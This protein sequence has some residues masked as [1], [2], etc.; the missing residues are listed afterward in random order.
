[1]EIIIT[2]PSI[3]SDLWLDLCIKKCKK[4]SSYKIKK[5]LIPDRNSYVNS[6]SFYQETE[7]VI[8]GIKR[9]I[10]IHNEKYLKINQPT[11]EHNWMLEKNI[12]KEDLPCLLLHSD[13]IL[14]EDITPLV[15]SKKENYAVNCN[16][17]LL[18]KFQHNMNLAFTANTYDI[19]TRA[20][21]YNRNSK[22]DPFI[23]ISSAVNRRFNPETILEY[24]DIIELYGEEKIRKAIDD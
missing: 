19:F 18:R 11:F 2:S 17:I 23:H 3:A 13:T 20:F 6:N 8:C 16:F 1:M 9:A 14:T 12:L 15:N 10:E 7:L 4:Y 22:N 21:D 5:I 24:K